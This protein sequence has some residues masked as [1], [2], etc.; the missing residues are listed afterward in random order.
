MKNSSAL[1]NSR[2]FQSYLDY[3]SI[4]QPHL[5]FQDILDHAGMTRAEVADSAHWFT[6]EQAD[7]FYQIIAEKTGDPDIARKAGRFGASSKGLALTQQYVTGLM[8]TETALLSMA[9]IISF[10]TKGATVEAKRL[11]PG[12]VEIISTP[13][14]DAEEKPYQCENRLGSFEAVPKLF[15]NVYGHVEHPYCFHREKAPA[16]TLSPGMIHNH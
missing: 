11:G 9:K 15:T 13:N 3:L 1:Y 16:T 4:S 14:P 2:I 12:K 6:Q 10:F 8:N 5:K 7:R